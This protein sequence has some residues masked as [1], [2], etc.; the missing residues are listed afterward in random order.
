MTKYLVFTGPHGS[1]KTTAATSLAS[2]LETLKRTVRYESFSLPIR[3]YVGH[4]LEGNEF[5]LE[6]TDPIE[7]LG[8]KTLRDFILREQQHMRFNY[9][10]RV[11]G[12]LMK[13]RVE[14]DK[15]DYCIVD[16]GTNINDIN[17]LGSYTLIDV[18]RKGVETAFPFTIPGADYY[19][20]N[21][22][23]VND[24][25]TAMRQLAIKLT[26]ESSLC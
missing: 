3:V 22:K 20:R 13:A 21:D 16:D 19:I 10:P 6:P 17:G 12:S 2:A 7:L 11:L 18:T 1:G 5:D 24:L 23:A 15:P 14:Q 25:D 26:E 9:G 8:G 4:L